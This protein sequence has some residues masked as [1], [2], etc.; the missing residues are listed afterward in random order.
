MAQSKRVFARHMASAVRE[1]SPAEIDAVSGARD[2]IVV[3]KDGTST[4]TQ[5]DFGPGGKWDENDI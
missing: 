5:S 4:F 2:H 3:G 1:L